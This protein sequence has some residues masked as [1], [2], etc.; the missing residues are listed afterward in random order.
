M[1]GRIL[2][3][4]LFTMCYLVFLFTLAWRNKQIIHKL[5]NE[6]QCMQHSLRDTSYRQNNLTQKRRN[7]MNMYFDTIFLS[8]WRYAQF[9]SGGYE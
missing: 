6:G 7:F 2:V 3:F 5:I 8:F 9:K 1:I 4:D